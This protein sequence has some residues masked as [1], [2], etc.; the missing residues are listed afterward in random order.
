MIELALHTSDSRSG[1][2][3]NRQRRKFEKD[4][5]VENT[6]IFNCKKNVELLKKTSYILSLRTFYEHVLRE[7]NTRH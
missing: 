6:Y 2:I 5:N 7:G 4:R 3:K 1:K